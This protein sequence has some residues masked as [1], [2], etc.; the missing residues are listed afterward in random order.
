[1]DVTKKTKRK[2][3][4]EESLDKPEIIDVVKKTKKTKPLKEGSN[5]H[6]TSSHEEKTIET[7][8]TDEIGVFSIFVSGLPYEATESDIRSFF[9]SELEPSKKASLPSPIPI[10]DSSIL[11][12]RAPVYHDTGRLRGYAH[13]DVSS[14]SAMELCLAR[15]GRYLKDRF[16]QVEK[17]KDRGQ[18]RAERAA[19]GIG[20]L[21]APHAR[22]AGCVTL[23]VKGLPYDFDED[24]VGAALEPLYGKVVSVRLA[25]HNQ[26]GMTKGFG[27]VQFEKEAD[28]E[29]MM[30]AFRASAKGGP[31]VLIGGRSCIVD[32]DEQQSPKA[33]FR[34]H[35][36]G[37][38]FSKT[39]HSR[40]LP[41]SSFRGRGRGGG[42]GGDRGNRG[43]DRGRR[44]GR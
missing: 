17:A 11:E 16:V 38:A 2:R 10:S 43:G 34:D 35:S 9:T 3:E 24:A 28:A 23:F 37:R 4:L 41:S 14:K 31:G 32:W 5:D 27:Y 6:K 1:M 21:S 36:S 8:I 22:P 13:I 42:G 40:L 39:E 30:S 12:I 44:G 20:G 33:S 18:G 7:V 26:T 19:Q 15:D 25:R 29:K